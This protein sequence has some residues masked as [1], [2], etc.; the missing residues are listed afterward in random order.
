MTFS[1]WRSQQAKTNENYKS[2]RTVWGSLDDPVLEVQGGGE[3]LHIAVHKYK[4]KKTNT[5]S[6]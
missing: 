3:S 1:I 6:E 2:N 4:A 5:L